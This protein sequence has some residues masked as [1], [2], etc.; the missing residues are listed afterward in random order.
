[1]FSSHLKGKNW[2]LT[3]H[4]ATGDELE[5]AAANYT[6]ALV[7]REGS[8]TTATDPTAIREFNTAFIER[9]RVA[10]SFPMIRICC[11]GRALHSSRVVRQST[12]W[13][14]S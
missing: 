3:S 12:R 13:R 11:S 8:I 2:S 5:R 9:S 14:W 4:P 6:G 1:M 10:Y 7:E